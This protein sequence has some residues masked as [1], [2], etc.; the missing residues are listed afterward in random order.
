MGAIGRDRPLIGRKE[1]DKMNMNIRC[2]VHLVLMS[3]VMWLK[4]LEIFS[5]IG[6]ITEKQSI[7][8]VQFLKGVCH[9]DFG[10]LGAWRPLNL[11]VI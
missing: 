8:L 3:S 9:S 4:A 10:F 2:A 7:P 5:R 11:K 1:T 6:M